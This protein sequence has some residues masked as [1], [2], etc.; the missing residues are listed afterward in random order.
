MRQALPPG[1]GQ[2]RGREARE[3]LGSHPVQAA[4]AHR[5]PCRFISSSLQ[6]RCSRVAAGQHADL[7][8]PAD[9]DS[10]CS[11]SG[12]QR[13]APAASRRMACLAAC[14]ALLTT[15]ASA[16]A[17]SGALASKLPA[18]ADSAWEAVGG[19]PP[20][21]FFPEEF[22]GTWDVTSVLL[23][24]ETP[25]GEELVP[26]MEVS[27]ANGL[28][29]PCVRA[30]ICIHHICAC[31][32]GVVVLAAS[33]ASRG[34]AACGRAAASRCGQPHRP[35]THSNGACVQTCARPSVAR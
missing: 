34:P 13:P 16:V 18:F 26:N 23:K 12:R 28:P 1:C 5:P 17:P 32:H 8:P 25:L 35:Q 7:T 29:R 10:A 33:H 31:A 21:L 9:S 24:V 14:S 19:G 22:L 27:P 11:T 20:D 15:V 3:A 2:T 30:C 6:R 4:V